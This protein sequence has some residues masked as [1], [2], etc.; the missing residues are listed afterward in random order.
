MNQQELRRLAG[1]AEDIEFDTSSTAS[2]EPKEEQII[3]VKDPTSYDPANPTKPDDLISIVTPNE[4]VALVKEC[5]AS[6]KISVYSAD[7]REEAMKDAQSRIETLEVNSQAE[8]YDDMKKGQEE[9]VD[10]QMSASEMDNP[11]QMK[12]SMEVEKSPDFIPAHIKNQKTEALPEMSPEIKSKVKTLLSELKDAIKA[13]ELHYQHNYMEDQLDDA[14]NCLKVLEVLTHLSHFL[15]NGEF[16][17]ATTYMSSLKS[18]L[19][20]KIPTSVRK[21]LHNG[22]KEVDSIVNR[23]KA[24]TVGDKK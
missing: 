5:G 18:S 19:Q 21:F 20:E 3:V 16:N 17:Q 6:C 8:Q 22:G 15:Q 1:I 24:I 14:G 10:A 12:E 23:F 13:H 7:N 2:P 11:V 4:L 9:M